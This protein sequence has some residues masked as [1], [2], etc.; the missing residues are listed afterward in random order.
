MSFLDSGLSST[1]LLTRGPFGG[2]LSL[3]LEAYPFVAQFWVEELAYALQLPFPHAPTTSLQYSQ[4]GIWRW[5][6]SWL[7]LITIL[8][9]SGHVGEGS[10]R[11]LSESC[12][13]PPLL[14]HQVPAFAPVRIVPCMCVVW[15]MASLPCIHFSS[16]LFCAGQAL[17]HS[18]PE[19]VDRLKSRR[20][21]KP[22]C[23]CSLL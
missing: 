23:C 15:L 22:G 7:S 12:F 6:T 9:C 10:L 1:R 21:G 20:R 4:D 16:F 13:Q 18:F 11:E 8:T 2:K 19:K 14:V 17:F 5:R 3:P